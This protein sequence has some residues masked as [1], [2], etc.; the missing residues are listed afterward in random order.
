GRGRRRPLT[1]WHLFQIVFIVSQLPSLVQATNNSVDSRPV[2]ILWFPAG[3][4]KTEAFLGLLIWHAFLD[5]LRGKLLGVTA[6]LRYPLRL[7]TY[8]QLQ[9]VAWV[10]G[11]AEEVR[12]HHRIPGEPFSLG[13]YVGQSTTPNSIADNQHKQLIASGV[14]SD[15]QRV[16]RCP[17][18]GGRNVG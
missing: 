7:L 12:I 13:Y 3:G 6:F 11:Q 8:Q 9:R 2:Q 16:F 14:P 1:K 17:Y 15:W 5:R 10:L 18:C 4:G